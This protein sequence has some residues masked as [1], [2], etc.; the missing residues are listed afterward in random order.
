D[1]YVDEL[2]LETWVTDLETVVDAAGVERFALLGQSQGAAI[3]IADAVRHPERVTKLVIIGGFSRGGL[4]RSP[5]EREQRR[6]MVTL[7][8]LG[9]GANEP[10]F[11]QLFTSRIMPDASKQVADAF[12]ELQRRTTSAECAARYLETVGEFDVD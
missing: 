6:A 3:S 2:S 12:N 7:M 4:R 8:R 11:R 9:W 10:A 1:W 5:E